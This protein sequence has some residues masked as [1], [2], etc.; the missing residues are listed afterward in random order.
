MNEFSTEPSKWHLKNVNGRQTWHYDESYPQN[1]V[2]KYWLG[3]LTERE[4][5]NLPEAKNAMDAARNGYKFYEKLQT[6]DGHWAG[7]YG[8]PLFLLPGLVITCYVTQTKLKEA[9]R[10]EMIRYLRNT[11]RADGSWGLHIAGEGTML[12]SC[13]NYVSARI[14]GVSASDPMCVKGREFILAH[15]GAE[16][17]A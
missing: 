9:Q 6:E 12:G 11:Q 14:L 1:L 8:G 3:I 15:G 2:D 16:Y 7:E 5:E 13:L 17:T 4:C 10:L